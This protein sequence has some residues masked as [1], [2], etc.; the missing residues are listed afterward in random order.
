MKLKKGA[1]DGAQPRSYVLQALKKHGVGVEPDG[2][3]HFVLT[4]SDGD[5][6]VLHIPNPVPSEVIV[7]LYRRFGVR[8]GFE[9]T[10]LVRRRT[11]H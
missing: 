8:H 9:V 5:P 6:F 7:F 10:A 3:D 2:V 11:L 1:W 4:D